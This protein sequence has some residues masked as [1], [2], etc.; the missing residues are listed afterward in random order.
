MK[1]KK[2]TKQIQRALAFD[3]P[4][5]SRSNDEGSMMSMTALIGGLII[6]ACVIAFGLYMLLSEQKRGQSKA[7]L[8]AMQMAKVL[9]DTDRVGQ[10]NNL[11][12]RNRELVFVSRQA[13]NQCSAQQYNAWA[14]LANLLCNEARASNDL[15]EAE[16]KQQ[17]EAS[18]KAIRKIVLEYNASTRESPLFVLPWWKSYDSEIYD[19]RIGSVDKVQSNALSNE[20]YPDLRQFDQ[21]KKYFQPI[22]NLY[23]GGVNAKLPEPDG[24]LIFKFASLPAPVENTI[25][26]ARLI[27][28]GLFKP[29]GQ[30]V[31][32]KK[33]LDPKVDQIPTAV[34]VTDR[35]SVEAVDNQ[36]Q[37][38]SGSCAASN[39]A[40]PP[41][42]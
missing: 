42:D 8:A 40:T 36:Q 20:I 34:E 12:A 19:V 25:S 41:P 26:P 37:V 22:S 11:I 13:V 27:N 5:S 29:A 38:R 1:H 23:V 30:V 3:G 10:M 32:N 33:F 28:S 21:E 4:K 7:D 17:A 35:M 39:G 18:Q 15:V 6:F 9:N 31:D 24:D 16:R 14:P 2:A